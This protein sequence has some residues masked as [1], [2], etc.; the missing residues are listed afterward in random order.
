MKKRIQPLLKF[1]EYYLLVLVLLAGFTP[2]F[3]FN[4]LS[5]VIAGIVILQI[6]YK[7]KISGLFI[8]GLFLI[9]N[10]FMLGALISEFT[11]FSSFD[12]S[13]KQLLVGGLAI[14]CLNSC[15][16]GIMIY[17]YVTLDGSSSSSLNY[18]SQKG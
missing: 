4:P 3:S 7:N 15:A 10:L 16:I 6:I 5:L 9:I 14:W 18:N 8:A 2:P 17:K 1:P 11:E 12:S 13:A